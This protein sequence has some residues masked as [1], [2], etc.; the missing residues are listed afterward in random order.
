MTIIAPKRVVKVQLHAYDAGVKSY[1]DSDLYVHNPKS[2]T[3]TWQECML[4]AQ[5]AGT[6]LAYSSEWFL[7]RQYLEKNRPEEETDFINGPLEWTGTVLDF[8]HEELLEGITLNDDT[9]IKNTTIRLGKKDGIIMPHKNS[10]VKDFDDRYMLLAS[11]LWGVQD[12][13]RELPDYAYLGI[14]HGFRPVVRGGWGNVRDGGRVCVGAVF[15]ASYRGFA[16]RFVSDARPGNLI[17][18]H[19]YT[20]LAEKVGAKEAELRARLEAELQPIQNEL[21]AAVVL[22]E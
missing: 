4:R 22:I 6:R 8:E 1:R 14:S 17:M 13:K 9:S 20:A 2:E 3:G 19:E 21:D 5:N 16:S 15:G 7:A 12:P 10:Y 18:P 11:H